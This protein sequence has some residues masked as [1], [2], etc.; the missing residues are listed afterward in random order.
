[1]DR[2]GGFAVW[3]YVAYAWLDM[4]GICMAWKSELG[5]G[6]GFPWRF[7]FVVSYE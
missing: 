3:W 5:F 2:D 1:L 4:V 7:G 6:F